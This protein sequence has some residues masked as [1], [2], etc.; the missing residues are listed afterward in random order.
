MF[1]VQP[2]GKRMQTDAVLVQ[3]PSMCLMARNVPRM[4]LEEGMHACQLLVLCTKL[5]PLGLEFRAHHNLGAL[6]RI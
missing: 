1:G 2:F 3:P 4:L 6:C 5:V